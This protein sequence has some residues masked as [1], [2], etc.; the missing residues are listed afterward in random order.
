[1]SDSEVKASAAARVRVSANEGESTKTG[2]R[3]FAL[4]MVG[5]VMLAVGLIAGT[6]WIL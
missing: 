3:L 2:S 5:L 4:S 6:A 1:M